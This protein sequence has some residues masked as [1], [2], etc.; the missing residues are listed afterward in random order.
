MDFWI[1]VLAALSIAVSLILRFAL[2]VRPAI[3]EAPLYL[4]V[5]VGGGS[6]LW[7]LVRQVMRLEFGAD[8]LAGLSI[9]TAAVMGQYLV[10]AIIVLMLAGGESLEA[11][12]TNRAGFDLRALHQRI[13]RNAHLRTEG[14][15]R[16]VPIGDVRVGDVLVILPHEA[17][18]VDALVLEGHSRMDESYLTGEPFEVSKAPGAAIYSGAINREHP[19][20]VKA[21]RLPEESRQ[22]QI[23]RLLNQTAAN[24]TEM[25]RLGDQLAAWY[26]PLA[27]LIAIGAW[28][29]SGDPLR[30]LAVT[31]I[32]TPCPLLIGIPVAILGGVS[33]AARRGIIV[34]NAALLERIDQCR[35]LVFDKTGTLTYGKP[36]LTDVVCAPGFERRDVLS[37]VATLEQYSKH[38]LAAAIL[39]AAQAEDVPMMVASEVSEAPGAGLQGMIDGTRVQ[40]TGRAKRPEL[41]LP[42][43]AEGLE[44]VVLFDGRL[45]ALIRFRDRPRAESASFV[46]HLKPSHGAKRVVLLSGD[47]ESEVRY[48]ARQVGIEEVHFSKSPEE[49]VA[50]VRAASAEG[51]T[52]YVGDGINDAPAMLAATVGIAL[53]AN[54]DITSQ[55]AAAVIL[56]SSLEKADELIHIGRRMRRIALETAVGGMCL[57]A[58]GMLAAAAG[59]LDPIAGAVAQELID[60]AAVLNATRVAFAGPRLAD[61]VQGGAG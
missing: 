27:V 2:G 50:I 48:L 36:V 3:A 60:L 14:G 8:L 59:L 43:T 23:V 12:A 47:L 51:M 37:K 58:V 31:V 15:H 57:S 41:A 5:A 40:I 29:W 44:C 6:I 52:L 16:D 10:A 25:R 20:I 35:I 49:K 45:A 17:A 26:T 4:V 39:K 22:A 38:P 42:K 46:S 19:L 21:V 55:A 1:A 13:P 61:F 9:L 7:R 54:S 30:F 32:A 33:L 53:G 18:P 56:D 34:K 28:V 24:R 11:Y